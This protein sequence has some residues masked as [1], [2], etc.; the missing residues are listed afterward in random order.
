MPSPRRQ[1]P[2]P[3]LA[4]FVFCLKPDLVRGSECALGYN[5]SSTGSCY[6]IL[7]AGKD[8]CSAAS[9]CLLEQGMRLKHRISL[10][11][12]DI[13]GLL[14]SLHL[15]T[16]S[17]VGAVTVG[18]R[19]AELQNLSVQLIFPRARGSPLPDHILTKLPPSPPTVGQCLAASDAVTFRLVDCSIQ[20]PFL[21]EYEPDG[22]VEVYG[23]GGEASSQPPVVNARFDR[24][25]PLPVE[26]RTF[27][28]FLFFVLLLLQLHLIFLLLLLLLLLLLVFFFLRKAEI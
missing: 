20:L 8:F 24:D 3:I 13:S 19:E 5:K 15:P 10:P 14:A 16:Q 26:N 4:I 23:G 7:T 11:V 21:C 25:F 22:V 1:L 17:W 18:T 28:S 6:R 9:Y 12:G 2:F 27:F